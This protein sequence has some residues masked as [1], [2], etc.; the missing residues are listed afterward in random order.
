MSLLADFQTKVLKYAK[1][2][3]E[4]GRAEEL[5]FEA[6]GKGFCGMMVRHASFAELSLANKGLLVRVR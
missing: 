1:S 6:W 5:D 2:M 4:V 3:P